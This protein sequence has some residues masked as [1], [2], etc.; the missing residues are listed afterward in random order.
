M[1]EMDVSMVK[2]A[3]VNLDSVGYFQTTN[4]THLHQMSNLIDYI[5]SVYQNLGKDMRLMTL[6]QDGTPLHIS[7]IEYFTRLR[8][9]IPQH[10]KRTC[11]EEMTVF[12]CSHSWVKREVKRDRE[13]DRSDGGRGEDCSR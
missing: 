12:T 8:D 3:N 13:W 11:F 6:P 9:D 5:R 1:V 7:M 4:F 10:A 2:F